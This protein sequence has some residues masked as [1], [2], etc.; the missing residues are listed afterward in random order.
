MTP[1]GLASSYWKVE[2]AKKHLAELHEALGAYF[3]SEKRPVR[4]SVEK[5]HEN[6]THRLQ[7]TVD[8]PHVWVFAIA[9]DIFNCLRSALDHAVWR[10]ASLYVAK[11]DNR[12]Q[13]PIIEDNALPSATATFQRQT[14]GLPAEAVSVI[15]KLQP[16]NRRP[17]APLHSHPLWCLGKLTNI[18]KHRQISIHPTVA[19]TEW[20][21]PPM[22]VVEGDGTRTFVYSR[23]TNEIPI[24]D[25]AVSIEVVFGSPTEGV[26]L[27]LPDIHDIVKFVFNPVLVSLAR[28]DP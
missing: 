6:Q 14:K 5:D 10:I 4:V 7:V 19:Y 23:S 9:G 3:D 8:E 26:S 21:V 1:G 28:F 24:S 22:S 25:P 12:I 27:A 13:F 2:R 16:Y 18:D 20:G 15:E 11:P 17:G